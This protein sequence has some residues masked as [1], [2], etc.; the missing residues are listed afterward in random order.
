MAFDVV[1]NLQAFEYGP[2]RMIC[3]TRERPTGEVGLSI[4]LYG[5]SPRNCWHETLRLD[6]FP[7]DVH[8]HWFGLSSDVR[9]E[10]IGQ[11]DDVATFGIVAPEFVDREAPRLFEAAGFGEVLADSGLRSR[12]VDDIAAYCRLTYAPP[13]NDA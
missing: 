13:H 1:S 12:V 3:A 5:R 11:S 6:A 10:A 4:E 8:Y 9:E 2:V 7:G